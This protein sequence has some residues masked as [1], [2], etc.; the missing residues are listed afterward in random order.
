MAQILRLLNI[1][2]ALRRREDGLDIPRVPFCGFADATIGVDEDLDA[3]LP[4]GL[5][6]RAVE[7]AG[8]PGRGKG[9]GGAAGG[10][11]GVVDVGDADG[12]LGGGFRVMDCKV[13]LG[14]G[15]PKDVEEGDGAGGFGF[16]REK[17]MSVAEGLN[18]QSRDK[19]H[20][21]LSGRSSEYATILVDPHLVDD[22]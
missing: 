15:G 13:D 5:A 21:K 17:S 14:K 16:C 7:Q 9:G 2:L 3:L 19:A 4:L 10:V 8:D 12:C 20:L 1:D 11:E 18:A 6:V 22:I